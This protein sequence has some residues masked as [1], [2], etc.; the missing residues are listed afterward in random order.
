MHH[1]ETEALCLCEAP[2]VPR[3]ICLLL[4]LVL[5]LLIPL[6]LQFFFII[7]G[8][9]TFLF[10]FL[11]SSVLPPW[12]CPLG[13]CWCGMCF[14]PPASR[15]FCPCISVFLS[16]IYIFTLMHY[17]LFRCFAVMCHPC[18]FSCATRHEGCLARSFNAV[19]VWQGRKTLHE[20]AKEHSSP[21]WQKIIL[22]H[23]SP[24][25][26]NRG[27]GVH[28]CIT[29]VL[30]LCYRCVTVVLLLYYCC[31][32]VVVSGGWERRYREYS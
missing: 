20:M 24:Q 19:I 10:V 25:S 18:A 23:S 32:P 12:V 5:F 4:L 9:N 7:R 27:H 30:L 17:Y 2:H 28:C 14:V 29:V 31:T 26:P 22:R 6:F 13:G 16:R 1:R 8:I 21:F 3:N 15:L 11:L